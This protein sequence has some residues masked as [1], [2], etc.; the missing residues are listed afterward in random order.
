MEGGKTAIVGLGRS[1]VA[2]ANLLARQGA[3]L[4]MIDRDRGIGRDRLPDGE[5]HLGEEDPSWL[6]GVELVVTSPGVPPDN[7]IIARADRDGLPIVSELELASRLIEAPIVA[8]TGTNGKSTVTTLIGD[9]FKAAGWHSFVGGNLG[10]PLAEA[11]GGTWDAIVVEVSSFQLERCNTFRPRVGVHLNLT[12]DHLDRYSDLAAYGQAKARL[13]RNQGAHDWAVLNRDDPNVW[14]LAPAISARVI[15]FGL[16]AESNSGFPEH[17][18]LHIDKNAIVYM[19]GTRRGRI[20]LE[21]FRAPGRHNLLN[22][23]AAAAA[24]LAM[25]VEPSVV[26]AAIGRFQGLAHR[27]EF[28]RERAGVTYIDDSKG[29][30]VG[31]VVEALDAVKPPIILIAG[32]VDKG[33][34]YGPLVKPLARKVKLLV[35]IGAAREKMRR[36]LGGA[37]ETEVAEGLAEAVTIADQRA[38]AGDTVMLSPACS[39]FDQF[40]SYAERGAVFKELVRSL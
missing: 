13:F 39:S 16:S 21:N 37:V 3:H 38:R 18:S 14:G 12:E 26:E 7:P 34:D 28:V 9:I 27:L 29:T 8:V 25:A 40:K 20:A 1:G 10:T 30:N 19:L 11:V 24:A 31:A 36:E 23:M 5:I 6:D 22:A 32:G 2:A 35:L 33:G 17:A 15:G 4:V